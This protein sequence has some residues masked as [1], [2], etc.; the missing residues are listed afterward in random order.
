MKKSK[1]YKLEGKLFRYDFDQAIVEYIA[2][3][4]KE[5]LEDEAERKR[6][7]DGRPLYGIDADGYM[8]LDTIGL[9]AENWRNKEARDVYL[10]GWCLDLDEQAAC[11]TMDFERYELPYLIGAEV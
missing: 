11:L 3:A 4:G 6:I 10:C 8:V 9:S 7:H 1:P 5:D 2:K